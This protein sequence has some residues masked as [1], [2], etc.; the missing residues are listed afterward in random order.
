MSVVRI[1]EGPYYRG[2]FKKKC[3]IIL[4]VHGKLSVIERC[5]HGEVRLYIYIYKLYK[6]RKLKKK[7]KKILYNLYFCSACLCIE[8][9]RD[10]VKYYSHLHF[11]VLYIYIYTYAPWSGFDYPVHL[12]HSPPTP[13]PPPRA[14]HLS[15]TAQVS[16]DYSWL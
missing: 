16:F 10:S 11:F 15:Q 7:I 1:R 9:S 14:T 6:D 12:S 4:S 13:T 8:H 2:F 5:P 3:M